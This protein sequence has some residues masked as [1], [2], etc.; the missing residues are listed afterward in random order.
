[1]GCCSSCGS[2][3]ESIVEIAKEVIKET[4]CQLKPEEK[5]E[6]I[7]A[8]EKADKE[9][10]QA[11]AYGYCLRE[12]D[13]L[14]KIQGSKALAGRNICH[15]N[16]NKPCLLA[17]ALAILYVTVKPLN[18]W[19][20]HRIDQ[21]I[22]YTLK[23]SDKIKDMSNSQEQV[24]KN[25]S[26]DDYVFDFCLKNC[27][28]LGLKGSL[29]YELE[30]VLS[31]NK[32]MIFQVANCCY[33]M[34]KDE[35]YHLFD[36]YPSMEKAEETREELKKQKKY[37]KSIKRFGERNTASWILFADIDSMLQ[38]LQERA[39]KKTWQE[40]SEYKFFQMQV[41][42]SQQTLFAYQLLTSNQTSNASDDKQASVCNH[43]ETV[44]W[45]ANSVPIWSRLKSRNADERYRG[46]PITKLKEYDI[47]IKER[48]WSLWG[49]IHPQAPVF[50]PISRG[51][52]YLA[53][54]VVSLCAASL[55]PLG[56][57]NSQLLDS[58]VI[59]GDRYFQQSISNIKSSDYEFSLEDLNVE[60]FL[61]NVAFKVH[62]E[63]VVYGKLYSRPYYNRMNLAEAL[64]YF[65]HYYQF[66]ILQCF[67]KC[68]AIG[69]VTG[70][71]GGYFMFDCQSR[72]HP[73]FSKDQ[74][75]SY[76]LRTKYLQIL[77]YCIVVTLNIPYYNV[78]FTLHKV[79]IIAKS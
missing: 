15:E 56:D 74:G 33:A 28:P 6:E 55:Y 4:E 73:L 77:L 75:T 37:P 25:I 79:N 19:T 1:M 16:Q 20:S 2:S 71:D 72:E 11:V 61:E 65:F 10:P 68:L 49:S 34:H 53:C 63:M 26:V 35:Y 38:Y 14:F 60:C 52:Q 50:K 22:D 24:F 51:K 42:S 17:S 46:L 47:E 3:E 70:H 66:G 43:Y 48:L 76:I 57:W 54:C 29:D 7:K 59:N 58:I 40:N 23:F 18:K 30:K 64:M 21:V 44:E 5:L 45:L 9:K 78:T 31:H 62:M 36:A 41:I 39:C 12:K 27:E 32:H 8:L 67:K 69:C 13:L